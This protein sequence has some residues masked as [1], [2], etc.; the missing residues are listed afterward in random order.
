MPITKEEYE[1]K[2]EYYDFQRRQEFNK[3][4]VFRMAETFENRVYTEYGT[5]PLEE[6]QQL[7]W[8]RVKQEEFDDPHEGWVPKDERL[9]FD[10]EKQ[11]KITTL[12]S[13]INNIRKEQTSLQQTNNI[14]F[15]DTNNDQIMG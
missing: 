8:A 11:N 2:K 15:C 5:V 10:W 13:R 7:L 6:L 9:R 3:E 4:Q 12:I 1:D 14:V